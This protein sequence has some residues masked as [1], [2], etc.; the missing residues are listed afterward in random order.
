MAL[1][2]CPECNKQISDIAEICPNCGYPIAKI[3]E[4][5]RRRERI[6]Q[7]RSRAKN[8]SKKSNRGQLI[9][10]GL[11]AIILIAVI[12]IITLVLNSRL[13][14]VEQS[15][16]NEVEK[17]IE[18]L[19]DMDVSNGEERISQAQEMYDGLTSKEQR[20]VSNRGELKEAEKKLDQIKADAVDNE[21]EAIGEVTISDGNAISYLMEEYGK[22]S[23]AQKKLLKHEDEILRINEEYEKLSIEHVEELINS[24]GT[25]DTSVSTKNAIKNAGIA[26][27][28]LSEDAKNKVSN[29]STL[30]E[31]RKQY[32]TL[33]VNECVDSINNIGTVSLLSEKAISESRRLYD[34]LSEEAKKDISN[35]DRL[36]SAENQLDKLKKEQE[37]QERELKP[38]ESFT[39]RNWKIDY[40]KS[41]ITDKI[42]P[43]DTSGYYTYYPADDNEIWIDLVFDIQNVGTGIQGI[44]NIVGTSSITYD[45][46]ELHKTPNLFLGYRGDID[47]VWSWD[48]LDAL[49]SAIL[50]VA[51]TL[52]RTAQN[53]GKGIYVDIELCGEEKHIDIR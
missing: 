29:Y 4:D 43:T 22:L 33:A 30:E 16:V 18:A 25:V 32:D 20:H 46:T 24:I 1:I 7:I 41:S 51:Y 34:S 13:D 12:I 2:N 36:E 15:N 14:A 35:Y 45:N 26:Y 52:P 42:L 37:M 27:T 39:A 49:D 21:Y 5:A 47:N 8:R 44:E 31:A 23:D 9:V 38:G 10:I 19:S 3:T 6:E 48:G 11:C 53:D 50:H 17:A 40:K 28:A